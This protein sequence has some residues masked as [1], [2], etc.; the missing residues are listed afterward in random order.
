MT[1][2]NTDNADHAFYAAAAQ[3]LRLSASDILTI[4]D[5]IEQRAAHNDTPP[6]SGHVSFAEAL[7]DA[8]NEIDGE[9]HDP[10]QCPECSPQAEAP[11][12]DQTAAKQV[13]KITRETTLTPDGAAGAAVLW[14]ESADGTMVSVPGDGV[15]ALLRSL[16]K[17]V[18]FA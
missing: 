11:A 15:E 4:A 6:P 14:L 10:C 5:E 1:T 9:E 16:T 12:Q 3:R 2:Q 18:S 17:I 13:I 7:R 8:L